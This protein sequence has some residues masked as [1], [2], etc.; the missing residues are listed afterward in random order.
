MS[1]CLLVVLGVQEVVHLNRR[2]T[3]IT[4]TL[5]VGYPAV[6]CRV[7]ATTVVLSVFKGLEDRFNLTFWRCNSIAPSF[8]FASPPHHESCQKISQ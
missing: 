3:C 6:G 8:V 2:H 7:Y 5:P 1:I 4:Y